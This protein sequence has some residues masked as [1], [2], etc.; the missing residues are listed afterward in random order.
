MKLK[1]EAKLKRA[2]AAGRFDARLRQRALEFSREAAASG[3]T[4]AG[5]ARRLGMKPNTLHRWHQRAGTASASAIKFVEVAG[6][7]ST[8]ALEVVWPTGHLVRMGAGDLKSVFTALEATC[9]PRG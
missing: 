2:L 8:E 7:P 9:C 4:V 1:A 3:E 5:T 6:V